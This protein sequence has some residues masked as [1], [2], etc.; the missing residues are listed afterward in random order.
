MREIRQIL[1]MRFLPDLEP[2]LIENL[3]YNETIGVLGHELGHTA[4][5]TQ[6]GLT[7]MMGIIFGNLSKKYMDNLEYKTDKVAIEHGL[8]YQLLAGVNMRFDH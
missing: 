8:G 4:F 1:K 5:F 7:G 2:I 6:T 3:G